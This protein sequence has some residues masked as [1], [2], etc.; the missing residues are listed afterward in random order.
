VEGVTTCLIPA[1]GGSKRIP[2]KN[3]KDFFG[4]PIMAYSIDTAVKSGLFD[5]IYVTTEDREIAEI[6]RLYGADI[7]PRTQEEAGDKVIDSETIAG[8]L[9]THNPEWL[10]YFYPCAPLV[11][12]E[13]LLTGYHMVKSGLF[14]VVAVT[15]Q[16]Y[17]SNVA[18]FRAGGDY[19]G[20]RQ[21]L[22]RDYPDIDTAED[23]ERLRVMYAARVKPD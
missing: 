8:F 13:D 20:E 12:V 1:R 4:K 9:Q 19:Y 10:C 7:H 5:E 6:A 18:W 14:P 16:F 17:W 21:Y 3:I 11:T 15:G 22:E 2:R 23:W